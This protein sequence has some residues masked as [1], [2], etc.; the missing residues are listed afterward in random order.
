MGDQ[1][2]AVSS[3][4]ELLT[5]AYVAGSGAPAHTPQRVAQQYVDVATGN[6]YQWWAGTWSHT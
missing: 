3:K 5:E 2:Q 4:S 6:V 1:T